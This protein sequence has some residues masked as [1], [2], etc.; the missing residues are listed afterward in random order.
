MTAL[1]ISLALLALFAAAIVALPFIYAAWRRLGV[2]D[3][4]LQIW[5]V[6]ARRGIVADQAPATQA[7]LAHA[8]RRCVFC[9][10][11]EQ[12]DRWLAS[13]AQAGLEDFCPN[14]T[15][16]EQLEIRNSPTRI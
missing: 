3:A 16:L 5:Q 8:V 12:C 10:S 1:F 13:N 11:I 14:A 2:R 6:M 7:K 4:N 15:L 9:P